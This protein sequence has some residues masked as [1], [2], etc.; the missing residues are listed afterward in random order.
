MIRPAH[1]LGFCLLLLAA[2]FLPARAGDQQGAP[3][4]DYFPRTEEEGGWRSLLPDQ[5]EPDDTQKAQIRELGG[6]DWE[7]LKA[8]WEHNAS[9]QAQRDCW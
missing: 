3:L 2:S 6:V 9:A 7:T 1:R 4:S 8:A 5:G